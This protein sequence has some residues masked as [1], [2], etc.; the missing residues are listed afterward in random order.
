MRINTGDLV[1][2][3]WRRLRPHWSF[4]A[5]I[6]SAVLLPGCGPRISRLDTGAV[7]YRP[8]SVGPSETGS[9]WSS[10]YYLP[11]ELADQEDRLIR[12]GDSV[13]IR[14]A[15]AFICDFQEDETGFLKR[16]ARVGPDDRCNQAPNAEVS[17]NTR[18]EI[19][20]LAT[21]FEL[22]AGNKIEFPKGAV[23]ENAARIVYFDDDVREVGQFLNFS[24]LPIY[25]PITYQGRPLFLRLV[26]LELDE[27]ESS[28]ASSLLSQLATLGKTAYPPASPVLGAL[29]EVGSA[30]L[31]RNGDDVEFR[32]DMTFDGDGGQTT[33]HA[34]LLFGNYLFIRHWDRN[35]E[36]PWSEFDLDPR[37]GRLFWASGPRKGAEY[38]RFTYLTVKITRN[39]RALE[40]DVGQTLAEFRSSENPDVWDLSQA[41]ASLSFLGEA[42]ERDALYDSIRS[43]IGILESWPPETASESLAAERIEQELCRALMSTNS[44]GDKDQPLLTPNQVSYALERLATRLFSDDSNGQVT[45]MLAAQACGSEPKSLFRFLSGTPV[46]SE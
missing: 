7:E 31:S 18:G 33:S 23:D 16:E 25:G 11:A 4:V 8:A 24:N 21:A 43:D 29:E 12:T 27:E 34:P 44:E 17:P 37:T 45:M 10:R 6:C 39:E 19:A 15:Q 40:Q 35:A 46:A 5:L 42:V 1:F 26:I 38:R 32:Y 41:A 36:I 9:E 22:G 30:L 2:S 14:I 13:S 28:V 3:V 20:L